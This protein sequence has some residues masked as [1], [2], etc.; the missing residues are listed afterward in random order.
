VFEAVRGEYSNGN[1]AIDDIHIEEGG[2]CLP[3][4]ACDFEEGFCGWEQVNV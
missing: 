4:A 1:K 3:M 2:T